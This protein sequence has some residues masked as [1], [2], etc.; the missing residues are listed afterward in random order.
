MPIGVS[1]SVC[2]L[3]FHVN[4]KIVKYNNIIILEENSCLFSFYSCICSYSSLCLSLS[5]QKNLPCSFMRSLL[6][7]RLSPL[8]RD[9]SSWE[10]FSW[11]SFSYRNSLYSRA[12]FLFFHTHTCTLPHKWPQ[13]KGHRMIA[14]SRNTITNLGKTFYYLLMLHV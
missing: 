4:V 12:F 5:V 8:S 3:I 14:N 1:V 13:L 11:V 7:I 6:S 10:P 9:W 2:E